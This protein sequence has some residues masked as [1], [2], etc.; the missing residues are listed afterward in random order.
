[1]KEQAI[2]I[3]GAGRSST[4]L[5]HYLLKHAAP[6]RWTVTVGDF[7]MAAAVDRVNGHTSGRAIAFDIT[8]KEASRAEIAKADV[9]VSL[10]PAHLHV[11][12]AVLCLSEKKHLLTASYVSDEMKSLDAEAKLNGLLFLN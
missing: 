1:M 11:Q 6:N 3:L 12:V 10:L 7:S 8:Q 2:L 5:I 9:V 4:A